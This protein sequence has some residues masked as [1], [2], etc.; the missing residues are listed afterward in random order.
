VAIDHTAG[1]LADEKIELRSKMNGDHFVE[2][3]QQQVHYMHEPAWEFMYTLDIQG[4]DDDI[5]HVMVIQ[6]Q[7]QATIDDITSI[8]VEQWT[9]KVNLTDL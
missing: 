1:R 9:S 5:N 6:A 2:R 8:P 3:L 4:G 7:L